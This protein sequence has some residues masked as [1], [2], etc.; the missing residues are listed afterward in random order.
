MNKNIG[1]ILMIVTAVLMVIGVYFFAQ[2]VISGDDA[3]ETDG[4]LQNSIILPAIQYTIYLVFGGAILALVFGL[5]NVVSNP[6]ALMVVGAA[7][8]VF[9]VIYLISSGQASDGIEKGW[10]EL[11][12]VST[13]ADAKSISKNV[14][15]GLYSFYWFAAIAVF[16][17]IAGEIYSAIK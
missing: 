5:K 12:E 4:E 11:M 3:I 8:A 9:V 17:A 13:E 10:Q 6:K 14:G 1:K 2:T 16:G 15:V 7:A